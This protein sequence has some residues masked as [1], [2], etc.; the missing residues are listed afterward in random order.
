MTADDAMSLYGTKMYSGSYTNIQSLI[1]VHHGTA[2]KV[3]PK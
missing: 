3:N 2:C 1:M